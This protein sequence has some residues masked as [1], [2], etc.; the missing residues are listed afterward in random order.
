[1]VVLVFIAVGILALSGIQTQSFTDVYATGRNTMA[2]D[3]AQR[4]ME[5]VRGAGFALAQSDSGV[6]SGFT[7]VS[8]VEF[9]AVDLKRVTTTVT[10][11]E[12]GLPRSLQL[13][14]LI[15]ER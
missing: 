13:V 4:Q 6:V 3:L 15:S 14:N 8:Y 2:L 1:M 11:Q 9:E 10:W 12:G 7:W 5:T